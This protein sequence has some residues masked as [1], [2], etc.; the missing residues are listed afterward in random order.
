MSQPLISKSMTSG[1][2]GLAALFAVTAFLC[3]IAAAK[4]LDAPFAFHA[5]LSAA[6][7]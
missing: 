3:V 6:A 7:S 2:S 5:A 4:A 1:E